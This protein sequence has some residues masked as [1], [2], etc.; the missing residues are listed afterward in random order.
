M[1][2]YIIPMRCWGAWVSRH[3]GDHST[4]FCNGGFLSQGVIIPVNPRVWRWR[5]CPTS[6]G[7]RN[8]HCCTWCN[9]S[10]TTYRRDLT[11][12]SALRGAGSR[13]SGCSGQRHAPA[14]GS[15]YVHRCDAQLYRRLGNQPARRSTETIEAALQDAQVIHRK[16]KQQCMTGML[17]QTGKIH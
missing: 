13:V 6:S 17:W 12:R 1:V 11:G 16:K 14:H 5:V 7:R 9:I 4:C 8:A 15:V 3:M 2:T 10:P